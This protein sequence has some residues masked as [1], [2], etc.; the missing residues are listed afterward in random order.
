MELALKK[1][2]LEAE[3]GLTI[4]LKYIPREIMEPNRTECQFFEAG[5]LETKAIKSGKKVDVELVHFSP[6]LAEAPEAEIEALRKRAVKSPFDFIDFWAVD[7][8]YQD[9]KPFEHHWQDFRTRKDR[10]LKT[11][12]DIGWEYADKGKK[13]ICVKVIDVFGVD[14]TTVIDVEA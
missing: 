3:T 12:T 8:T 2:A 4:R 6:A 11:S 13:R 14:T 1:Q 7:F 10:S 5:Y 9:G